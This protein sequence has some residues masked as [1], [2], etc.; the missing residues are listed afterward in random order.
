MAG[1]TVNIVIPTA[2]PHQVEPLDDAVR[3]KCWRWG[4]RAGKTRAAFQAATVGHGGGKG[5]LDG[6][7]IL[8]IARDYP[9]SDVIWRKEIMKRFANQAGFNINKQDKRLTCLANGGTLTISSA[10]NI[11][12]VRGGDWDG[13]ILDEAAHYDLHGVWLDVIRPGLA[14]TGGWAILMSTTKSGSY[15]NTLC[16]TVMDESRGK[17]WK[18]WYRT[19]A[20]NPKI[21]NDEFQA[22]IDEYDD[23][24]KLAQ[25]VHAE[26][27][28]PG[29]FAFPEWNTAVH[30][31]PLEPPVYWSWVGCLDWGYMNPGWFGLCVLGPDAERFF[32]WEFKFQQMEPYDVGFQIGLVLVSKFP[33][34][35]FIVG[36]SAMFAR[37]QSEV[38]VADEIQRGLNKACK[39]MAPALIT[40]PK[41]PGSR[42][43]GKILMHQALKW[44]PDPDSPNKPKGPWAAPRLRFHPDCAYAIRTLPKLTRDERNPEDVDTTDEDHAYDAIRYLLLTHAPRPVS[45]VE[46]GQDEHPGISREGRRKKKPWERQF[47]DAQ[48]ITTR[49]FRDM[50]IKA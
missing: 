25:E 42:M 32:R 41:G 13:V 21:S 34:P 6:G 24:V 49:Y 39:E 38:T 47:D 29:G 15:F 17:S 11:D 30:V 36:D 22:L 45:Q 4:R 14:D 18:H 3:M 33:K 20:D 26:L 12:S 10:E 37:S 8:W 50:E 27:V 43:N 23:E 19:A 16:E 48:E 40:A 9:N 46:P 28:V 31:A 35:M 1:K 5:F 7:E 2:L 44:T